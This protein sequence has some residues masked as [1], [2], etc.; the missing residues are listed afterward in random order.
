MLEAIEAD[1]RRALPSLTTST[2]LEPLEDPASFADAAIDRLDPLA[3]AAWPRRAGRLPAPGL[4]QRQVGW[5]ALGQEVPRPQPD[6]AQR[7]L[8]LQW[9]RISTAAPA[10]RV[11]P[12]ATGG[13]R[14]ICRVSVCQSA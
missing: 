9:R 13:A 3:G 6:Q 14:R 8:P 10:A 2:H 4:R 11:A 12:S 7:A 5:G 1:L